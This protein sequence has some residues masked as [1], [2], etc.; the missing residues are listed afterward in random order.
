MRPGRTHRS[1]T[2]PSPSQAVELTPSQTPPDL[3]KLAFR[4]LALET[5]TDGQGLPIHV[6]LTPSICIAA[7][8]VYSRARLMARCMKLDDGSDLRVRM[9]SRLADTPGVV[10]PADGQVYAGIVVLG[11]LAA[12]PA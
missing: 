1:S 5:L 10:N 12:R 6:N 11:C 3:W 2:K 7:P 8:S 4:R 9:E